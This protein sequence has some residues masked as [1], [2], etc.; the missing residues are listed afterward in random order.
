MLVIISYE[1]ERNWVAQLVMVLDED[2][3]IVYMKILKS[4]RM[5]SKNSRTSKSL[6]RYIIKT[7]DQDRSFWTFPRPPPRHPMVSKT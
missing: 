3:C 5:G 2:G 6:F 4:Y 1:W 7:Q